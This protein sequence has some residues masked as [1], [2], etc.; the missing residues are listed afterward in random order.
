MKPADAL[1]CDRCNEAT[2]KSSLEIARKQACELLPCFDPAGACSGSS[3]EYGHIDAFVR[4]RVRRRLR[5]RFARAGN[6]F[7]RVCNS[8][9]MKG[10]QFC[11]FG[12]LDRDEPSAA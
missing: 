3:S 7:E 11:F 9:K 8:T 10:Q 6:P 2:I 4:I 1:F 12:F 5:I